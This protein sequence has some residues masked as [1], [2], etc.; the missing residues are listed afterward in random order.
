MNNPLNLKKVG[1]SGGSRNDFEFFATVAD[2][3]RGAAN[4]LRLYKTRYGKKTP[5]EMV[6]RWAPASDNNNHAAYFRNMA[7]AGFK[8][9]DAEIDVD[10]PKQMAMLLKGMATAECGPLA[11][12]Y[13]VN[14][15]A[16]FL[17]ENGGR[18][19]RASGP[20]DQNSQLAARAQGSILDPAKQIQMQNALDAQ[21][22]KA[23]QGLKAQA[24]LS[25]EDYV[26]QC[27]EGI[28]PPEPDPASYAPFGNDSAA[29]LL[30]AQI[31]RQYGLR[32]NAMKMMPAIAHNKIIESLRPV[33]GSQGFDDQNKF[34]HE[35]QAQSEK[36][37]KAWSEDAVAWLLANDETVRAAK[38]KGGDEYVVALQAAKAQR[39]IQDKNLLSKTE[40]QS[41]ADKLSTDPGGDPGVVLDLYRQGFGA[42]FPQIM[43]EIMPKAGNMVNIVANMRPEYANERKAI[44]AA[45]KNK[46]FEKD[47]DAVLKLRN[48]TKPDFEL[49]ILNELEDFTQT[50]DAGGN[51]SM[52]ADLRTSVNYLAKHYLLT[53]LEQDTSKA[54][55]RAAQRVCLE[56]YDI[57]ANENSP[58]LYRVPKG[59]ASKEIIKGAG[60]WLKDTPLDGFSIDKRSDMTV[61]KQTS[62]LESE[63][64]HQ[65]YWITNSDESGL[66][67]LINGHRIFDKKGEP[68]NVT[69]DQ[70]Y[71]MR[72][73]G[74]SIKRDAERSFKRGER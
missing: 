2:G 50:L 14:Q 17:T 27:R 23:L 10:D 73:T 22:A 28:L 54:V 43:K 30:E 64:R 4:Q 11:A 71:A 9:L 56:S 69:W 67:L 42:H 32:L 13:S 8:D 5:R 26:A 12:R 7:A 55:H 74:G 38:A 18:A 20:A 31:A 37:Q 15:I 25:H 1:H 57:Q 33:P 65:A 6:Q 48:I 62:A 63:I 40:A 51:E 45:S 61:S 49:L 47:S 68:V 72:E 35:L 34:F 46:D 44:I 16:G 39:G 53:G 29:K 60:N 3:F 66:T 36:M 52:S 59:L 41:L 24:K 58:V 70:L 19:Q 21:R